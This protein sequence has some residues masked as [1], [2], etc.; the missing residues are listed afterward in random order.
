MLLLKIEIGIHNTG[1]LL[2]FKNGK[3]GQ[4]RIPIVCEKILD[5]SQSE[6]LIIR[7]LMCF[8]TNLC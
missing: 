5:I 2:L 1:C 8:H 7:R 4:Q 3:Y 6:L